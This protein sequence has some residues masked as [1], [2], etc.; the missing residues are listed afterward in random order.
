MK[1]LKRI[2]P[3]VTAL[4]LCCGLSVTTPAYADTL[5][6]EQS[7]LG[8]LHNEEGLNQ[9]DITQATQQARKIQAKMGSYQKLIDSINQQITVNKHQTHSTQVRL[10]Q[11]NAQL[12]AMQKQLSVAQNEL[13]ALVRALYEDGTV[14]YLAVLFQATSFSDLLSRAYDMTLIIEYQQNLA[15]QIVSLNANVITESKQQTKVYQE[16]ISKRDQLQSLENVDLNLQA[17]QKKFL[18]QTT[19]RIQADKL[20]QRVLTTQMQL[21]QSQIQQILAQI[22]QQQRAIDTTVPVIPEEDL[23]YQN[24]SPEALYQYVQAHNSTF[25]LQDIETICQA[26]KTYDVNPVLLV[27]ITGQ[28]QSF[29]PPGPDANLIRNNP[30]NVYYSWQ[31]YNTNLA[32]AANIAADTLRHKL[33]TPPPQ[34]ENPII[35]A[36]DPRNP[37]GIYAKDRN[38]AYGV[39][40]I[41]DDI[42]SAVG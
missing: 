13:D 11:I 41:Y 25:S 10:S 7:Q 1:R 15:H 14:S 30:F 6:D 5:F 36:N 4:L 9:Q 29:V 42:T 21:T 12:S 27:A 2:V 28:E 17:T 3:G 16:L 24:I 23:D 22:Y 19:S 8:Q 37:W 32:D 31:V 40:N 20:K 35:W 38:W 18:D 34:G 39:L 26:G 33:S